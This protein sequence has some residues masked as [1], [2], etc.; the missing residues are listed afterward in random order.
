M[1]SEILP[2]KIHL[3]GFKRFMKYDPKTGLLTWKAHAPRS[4]AKLGSQVGSVNNYGAR[5]IGLTW[6]GVRRTFAVYRIAWYLHTG[7]WPEGEIQHLN[8]DRDDNRFC[9]LRV[10]S[11]VRAHRRRK[12]LNKRNQSGRRGV[13]MTPEGRWQAKAFDDGKA[14]YI[15][16]FDT[17]EDASKAVE[18]FYRELDGEFY[19]D[20]HKQ[21]LDR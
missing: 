4:K 19:E 18:D 16:R 12:K 2:D 10:T 6:S 3:I 17:V 13:Y 21:E 1:S 9:N 14:V 15:A 11:H 7:E 8:H 20:P 5:R